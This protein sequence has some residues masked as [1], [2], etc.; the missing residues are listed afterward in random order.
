MRR[1]LAAGI[2]ILVL[3][4]A[5]ASPARRACHEC[6]SDFGGWA[7]GAGSQRVVHRAGD[8]HCDADGAV[9]G[10]C[11][12]D[13]RLC[14]NVRGVAGCRPRRLKDLTIHLRDRPKI[15]GAVDDVLTPPPLQGHRTT[16]GALARMAVPINVRRSTRR[17]RIKPVT[18]EIRVTVRVR[19]RR[20]HDTDVL[21]LQ[22]LPSLEGYCFG[23][24]GGPAGLHLAI[25]DPP[26]DVPPTLDLCLTGCD[27]PRP[28]RAWRRSSGLRASVRLLHRGHRSLSF[29]AAYRCAWWSRVSRHGS[30]RTSQPG[31]STG[32]SR[33]APCFTSPR[34]RSTSARVACRTPSRARPPRTLATSA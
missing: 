7:A 15:S 10:H 19:G 28:R 31:R 11:T 23:T 14:V 22:C 8:P 5:P 29:L 34:I 4:V 33:S 18:R 24:P 9:D 30:S 32:R 20:A 13:V 25:A 6:V 16:C 21:R 2:V 26:A 3:T 12:F 17:V 27:A 1:V